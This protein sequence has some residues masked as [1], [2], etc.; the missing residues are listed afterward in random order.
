MGRPAGRG[1]PP[2]P[3]QPHAGKLRS[4]VP[5]DNLRIALGCVDDATMLL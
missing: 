5:A 3:M 1:M 4:F 2:A